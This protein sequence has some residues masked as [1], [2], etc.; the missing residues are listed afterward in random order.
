MRATETGD[1]NGPLSLDSRPA[2]DAGSVE[3]WRGVRA[4]PETELWRCA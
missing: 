2:G 3:G 1:Y 4:R